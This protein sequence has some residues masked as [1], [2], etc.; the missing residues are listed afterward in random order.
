V[1]PQV[2]TIEPLDYASPR[3]RESTYSP[4]VEICLV[5]DVLAL[6]FFVSQAAFLLEMMGVNIRECGI[7]PYGHGSAYKS[8]ALG[9]A[10]FVSDFPALAAS[11]ADLPRE[12]LRFVGFCSFL[13]NVV[14]FTVVSWIV[15]AYLIGRSIVVRRARRVFVCSLAVLMLATLPFIGSALVVAF[16]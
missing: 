6:F 11:I 2:V 4:G 12:G 5:L 3:G 13:A 16:D 15:T 7:P 8:H 9:S 10:E 14:T 1:R